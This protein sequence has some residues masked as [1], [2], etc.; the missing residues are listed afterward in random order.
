MS[1]SLG[2]AWS[3][4]LN[5]YGQLGQEVEGNESDLTEPKII[6]RLT[7]IF[8]IDVIASVHGSSFAIDS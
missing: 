4:G 2:N 1:D 6:S 3:F 7:Q 8:V 5:N